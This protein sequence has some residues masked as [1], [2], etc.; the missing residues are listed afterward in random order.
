MLHSFN[1]T[2]FD[3]TSTFLT[4]QASRSNRGTAVIRRFLVK[5]T[6]E[7]RAEFTASPTGIVCSCF[8]R[9]TLMPLMG[10]CLHKASSDLG[11]GNEWPNERDG[12]GTSLLTETIVVVLSEKRKTLSC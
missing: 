7:L 3:S 9:F 2:V 8:S 11:D 10:K 4:M 1:L 12:L 5:K 6:N